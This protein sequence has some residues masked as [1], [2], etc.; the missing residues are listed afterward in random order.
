MPGFNRWTTE[1]LSPDA[2]V[3]AGVGGAAGGGAGATSPSTTSTG[4]APSPAPSSIPDAD[5]QAFKAWQASRTGEQTKPAQETKQ[6]EADPTEI[7]SRIM[8]RIR[9]ERAEQEHVSGIG[10]FREGIKARAKELA[11]GNEDLA[12]LIEAKLLIQADSLRKPYGDDHDL[13]GALGVP[14]IDDVNKWLDEQKYTDR[15]AKIR[16]SVVKGIA[17][18]AGATPR[19]AAP[20]TDNKG[21]KSEKSSEDSANERRERA[22]ALAAEL[23]VQG[24]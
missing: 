5:M 17:R 14:T 6:P 1:R 10:K 24:D 19:A 20:N 3:G 2:P 11:D 7:E 15:L 9:R 16:G 23:G 8:S 13:K 18:A 12:D 22:L 4:A 21:V